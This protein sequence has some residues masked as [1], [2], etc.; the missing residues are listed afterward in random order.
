MYFTCKTTKHSIDDSLAVE[1]AFKWWVKH[2]LLQRDLLIGRLKGQLI[3]NG[4][5]KFR[6]EIPGTVEE[7]VSLD[8]NNGNTLCQDSIDKEMKNVC[9]AFKLLEIHGKPPVDYTKINFHSV[10]DFKLDMTIKD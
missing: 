1:P 2:T 8:K 3:Q 4:R 10:F 9:I 7:M 5:I 6:V